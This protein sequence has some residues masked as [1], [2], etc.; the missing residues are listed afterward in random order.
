M[1][2]VGAQAAWRLASA[3]GG[4][5]GGDG[6]HGLERW[7]RVNNNARPSLNASEG[8]LYCQAVN[9]SE[10]RMALQLGTL[11]EA[12]LEAGA[13]PEKATG[14][15]RKSPAMTRIWRIFGQT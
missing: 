6:W 14:R 7:A 4:T 9:N 10:D 5:D 12:L 3:F 8:A 11:R 15:L 13:S 2:D 1:A